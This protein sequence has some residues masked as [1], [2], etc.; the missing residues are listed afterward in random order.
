MGLL[1][2]PVVLL[3]GALWVALASLFSGLVAWGIWKLRFGLVLGPL[4]FLVSLFLCWYLPNMSGVRVELEIRHL[5]ADCG[6]T[7]HRRAENVDGVYAE[8]TERRVGEPYHHDSLWKHYAIVEY[9][10]HNNQI[11]RTESVEGQTKRQF[12]IIPSRTQRYGFKQIETLIGNV[13]RTELRVVDFVNGDVLARDV[14]YWPAKSADPRQFW[15]YVAA[16]LFYSP[17]PCQSVSN[18]DFPE[19]LAKVLIPKR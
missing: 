14:E 17:S 5:K 2:V 15:E 9:L 11:H 8:S 4:A 10:S 3:L 19:R 13:R 16:G 6:W 18:P 1:L 7:V 12:T